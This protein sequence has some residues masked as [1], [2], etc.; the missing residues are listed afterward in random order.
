MGFRFWHDRALPANPTSGAKRAAVVPIALIAVALALTQPAW[1][2]DSD[3]P[4]PLATSLPDWMLDAAPP[5]M[6]SP[7]QLPSTQPAPAP[8][9][10]PSVSPMLMMMQMMHG[11]SPQTY[12]SMIN[13]PPASPESRLQAQQLAAT[14]M[15][16]GGAL[17][18]EAGTAMLSALRA[19]D[20]VATQRALQSVRQAL[21]ELES[22]LS[23]QQLLAQGTEPQAAALDWFRRQLS[24]E[25][26]AEPTSPF[27][28]FGLTWMHFSGMATLIVLTL[29]AMTFFIARRRQAGILARRLRATPTPPTPPAEPAATRA[30]L[31]TAP[32]A[33][34]ASKPV[35]AT[36]AVAGTT[37]RAS[38][39]WSGRLRVAAII[40]ETPN[41][42]TYR[43][44]A[45]GSGPLPF[46][47][48]PGQFLNVTA[49]ID[50]RKTKRSYTIASPP[51]RADLIEITVKRE[52][53]G[54]M[55]RYLHDEVHAGDLL[56]VS[57]P[58]GRF[59]FEGK[60]ADSIVL[61]GGGVGST[62]LMSVLR[63]L[64]DRAWPGEIFL[65]YCARTTR[66]FLYRDELA[67]LQRR[68]P[69]LHVLATMTRSEGDTWFGPEGRLTK[70][71][72]T[73][74]VP[75]LPRRRIHLCGPPA[76]MTVVREMLT[77][78]SVPAT[79]VFTESFATVRV[80]PPTPADVGASAQPPA[81]DPT[82]L[83]K[84][85]FKHSG[86]I[87]P[88]APNQTVL[89]AAEAIG[90]EIEY[91]C[92]T[93]TCGTCRVRLLEGTITMAVE[94]GLDPEDKEAG[95]ILACQ[96]KSSGNLS[97]DA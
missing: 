65:L 95:W 21:S 29:S 19:N 38:A 71:M 78:L 7:A 30:A 45:E 89:E 6:L 56:A 94:E 92:R 87:A 47:F 86:K 93:G 76:M 54:A 72:L 32:Q 15:Q 67:V 34:E 96:A 44:V 80:E 97:V 14:R 35:A 16:T 63:A 4:S 53:H 1:A 5:A 52:D 81:L 69:N 9:P 46:S 90:V 50:G 77:E 12:P 20:A 68:H 75:D 41:I 42:K 57:A 43:L 28:P 79:N 17:L 11:G 48:K 2:Q 84:V 8:P 27:R 26:A 82:L 40:D 3:L 74:T 25:A 85:A 88:L 18:V 58:G 37:A 39:L 33:V 49:E 60:E 23:T 66:D 24:V 64:T 36:S 83:P 55:S 70:D 61:I 62:P 73:A 91:S 31:E 10:A 59:T 51:T 22:G 13:L